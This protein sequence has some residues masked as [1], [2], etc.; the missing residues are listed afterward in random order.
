MDKNI[1]ALLLDGVRTI[2]CRFYGENSGGDLVSKNYTYLTTDPSIKAGDN[3]V[4]MVGLTPKV[5]FVVEAHD[6]LTI[7]PNAT[8]EYKFIVGKVDM[9][10]YSEMLQRHKDL[11]A[12]LMVGYQS[13]LRRSFAETFIAGLPDD[14]RCEVIQLLGSK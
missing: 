9:T 4:V 12:K 14:A 13:N 7:E 11:K 1:V 3:V 5:V 2:A 8:T 6:D 10:S